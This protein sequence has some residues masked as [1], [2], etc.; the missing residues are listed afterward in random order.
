MG[1]AQFSWRAHLQ[2]FSSFWDV[3][4]RGR[5]FDG[6]EGPGE[7]ARSGPAKANAP[8]SRYRNALQVSDG[9]VILTTDRG[10]VFVL[11][12]HTRTVRK[13]RTTMMEGR[14]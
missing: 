9:H 6:L 12:L 8:A 7:D 3:S 14:P 2:S 5:E 1:G 11:D 10:R 4:V 13:L